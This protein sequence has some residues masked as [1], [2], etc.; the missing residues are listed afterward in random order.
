MSKIRR[1]YVPGTSVFITTVCH[2]R[3]NYLKAELDKEL[4]LAVMREVKIIKSFSMIAYVIMDNHFHFII[5]P[6]KA[7]NFSQIMQ[8]IKQRFTNRYKKNNGLYSNIPIWQP[9]FW[10]HVIRNQDDMYRHIDYIHYNPV[11]HRYENSPFDYS[12]SSFRKY[13]DRGDYSRE[14][15]SFKAPENISGMDYE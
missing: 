2:N 4:L 1:F 11:K 7:H 9:R 13:V 12:W 8:S 5:K 6:D 15:A 3:K 14:W 10:D